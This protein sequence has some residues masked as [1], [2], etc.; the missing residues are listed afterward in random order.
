[1]Y[2]DA[3][4]QSSALPACVNTSVI[5]ETC[6]SS[7]AQLRAAAAVAASSSASAGGMSAVVEKP[8]WRRGK[9]PSTTYGRWGMPVL[10][11]V[12]PG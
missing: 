11:L 12:E 7:S 5:S 6:H 9:P 3:R 8:T 10:L 1:M 2:I 4:G